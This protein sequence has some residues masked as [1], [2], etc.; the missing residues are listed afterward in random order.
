[1]NLGKLRRKLTV[2]GRG[3]AAAVVRTRGDDGE[4]DAMAAGTTAPRVRDDELPPLEVVEPTRDQ[5]A[6]GRDDTEQD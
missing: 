3:E 2:T 5:Q 4:L 6:P 1:M